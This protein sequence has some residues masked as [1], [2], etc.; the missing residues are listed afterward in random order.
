MTFTEEICMFGEEH[1]E[2]VQEELAAARKR[3]AE[4]ES[5]RAANDE[6]V[7]PKPSEE[8][9]SRAGGSLH[10]EL[11]RLSA[12]LDR[13]A[14]PI[15]LKDDDHRIVFANQPFFE[16]FGL[17]KD[18]V[19]GKT[20]AEEVPPDEREH[21]LAVDRR[22][23]DTGIPD[24]R[25]ESLT[26]AHGETAR[27]IRTSKTRFVGSSGER[28]LVGSIHDITDLRRS[29]EEKARLQAQFQRSQKLES[30]GVLA[31]GIAHD[32]NNL[33]Q[34]IQGQ[35][36]L[37]YDYD[38]LPSDSPVRTRLSKILKAS[39]Q[40]AELTSQ[41]LAY[42]GKGH[43]VFEEL[44]FSA[45]VQDMSSLLKSSVSKK[46]RLKFALSDDLPAI[47]ADASQIRQVVM[48]LVTNAS[49]AV[50][51]EGGLVTVRT[52]VTQCDRTLLDEILADG[53]LH[54]G[55][56]PEGRYTSLEVSDNGCGMNGRG[57]EDEGLRSL[58]FDQVRWPGP[59]LG[60][61]PRHRP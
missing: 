1:T 22:V 34:A 11:E 37:A 41:M 59:W 13:V 24:Q 46:A 19:I 21:F 28:F 42:S 56:L 51:Q 23:L 47:N 38:D 2:Q 36:E 12:I 50:G 27:I 5:T 40:A 31:G 55:E 52:G 39:R 61:G 20:L 49:D 58:L 29:E 25:E 43:F 32:F 57:G 8:M 48:N 6:L 16:I 35:A 9:R 3:I 15:F 54:E 18:A 14:D 30:L 33:L 44:D 53:E 10:D 7:P 4:L 45:L 26:A 60:G 17:A